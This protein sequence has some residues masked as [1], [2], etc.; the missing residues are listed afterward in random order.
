MVAL[1]KFAEEKSRALMLAKSSIT[2]EAG[3]KKVMTSL[4]SAIHNV[5]A[6]KPSSHICI[7]SFMSGI[8]IHAKDEELVTAKKV[9]GP[10]I[11]D[12]IDRGRIKR[13]DTIDAYVR[14]Y[15]FRDWEI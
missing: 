5:L 8:A 2:Q 1:D 13:H 12:M 9:I 10:L 11:H 4:E 7:P 6:K 14:G 3:N 15:K